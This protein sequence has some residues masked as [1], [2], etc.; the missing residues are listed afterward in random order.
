MRRNALLVAAIVALLCAAP[1]MCRAIE[2]YLE[3]AVPCGCARFTALAFGRE[4]ARALCGCADGTL[5]LV[6]TSRGE[7]MIVY[8]AGDA[9]ITAVALSPD[10]RFAAAAPKGKAPVILDLEDGSVRAEL[11]EAKGRIAVLEFSGDG[12]YLAAGGDKKDVVVW[13]SPSGRIRSTLEGHR[14]EIL[15]IAFHEAEGTIISAARDGKAIVWDAAASKPL[16][17]YDIEARTMTGSG[18]DVTAARVS[19]DRLFI[20]VGIEEHML[21]KGGREMIFKRHLA[22]FDLSKGVLLKVLEDNGPK[23]EHIALYPGNCYAAF[24]NSTLREH[25]IALRNIETGNLDLV[26]PMK[27]DCVLLEFSPDGRL[28]AGAAAPEEGGREARLQLWRVD[29]EMPASGCFMG[30]VRLVSK[31]GPVPKAG[32]A[33]RIAA[34]LPFDAGA[35]GEDL[36]RAAANFMESELSSRA[37]LKLVERSRIDD[38]LR[39]LELQKSALVDRQSAVK[40]G[41]LLG[42]ALMITGNIDRAGADL[43]ISARAIDVKTGEILGTAQVHCGQC[44]ADDI[45]DAIRVLAPALV[46][47]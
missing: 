2:L 32:G 12:S 41:K 46:E 21:Q 44:G 29:Y 30:R 47:K 22:F 45:F 18:I 5:V 40:A 4:S 15:A 42:A 38:I 19:A 23:I 31:G 16:R 13:E 28:L 27:S 6:D 24:D 9:G 1:R 39:E 35:G 34:I 3:R 26:Y 10:G 7:G 20:A 43:V 37:S 36:G 25:S 14:G 33:P 8:D 11:K 17:Q